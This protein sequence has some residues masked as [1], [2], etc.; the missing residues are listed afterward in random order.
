MNGLV[1]TLR[2]LDADARRVRE[3]ADAAA[4]READALFRARSQRSVFYPLNAHRS[5]ERTL[6]DLLR[7]AVDF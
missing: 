4:L 7:E 6:E 1:N 3:E 2:K 5:K